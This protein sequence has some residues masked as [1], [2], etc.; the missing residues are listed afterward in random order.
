MGGSGPGTSDSQYIFRT[1]FTGDLQT[2]I[3][4]YTKGAEPPGRTVTYNSASCPGGTRIV[5]G[6]NVHCLTD[7]YHTF[8]NGTIQTIRTW[9][10]VSASYAGF[11]ISGGPAECTL[12]G[13]TIRCVINGMRAATRIITLPAGSWAADSPVRSL[14]NN[15]YAVFHPGGSQPERITVTW[16][17]GAPAL[18]T[19]DLS[20]NAPL[21]ATQVRVM[22]NDRAVANEDCAGSCILQLDA[23]AGSYQVKHQWLNGSGT[24][25]LES[26]SAQI[27]I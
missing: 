16:S 21:G 11:T 5:Y 19:L 17:M 9:D 1:R 8:T 20:F 13:S 27:I 26:A 2:I 25:L 14:G 10:A 24:V 7:T 18:S 22:L 12:S 23:P 3:L 15:S 6:A 4:P